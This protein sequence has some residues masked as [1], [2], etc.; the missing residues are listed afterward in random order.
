MNLSLIVFIGFCVAAAV[1]LFYYLVVFT[2][3]Y[4]KPGKSLSDNNEGVSVIICSRNNRAFLE[5]NLPAILGQDH[6]NFEVV[7]VNDGSTDGTIDF[8]DNLA[9]DNNALNVVHLD[10][11]ERFHRGKKFAQT[12]G[13]KA[14]KN[15]QLIFTDADCLP[16]SDQWLKETAR[17][18]TPGKSIILGVGNYVRKASLTNWI[19]QLETFHSLLLYIN[20]AR[21]KMPYMGVG[22][23]LAYRRSLFFEV[24]GFAS[25]QHLL[26]GDDD[27]FVNET[28]TGSNVAISLNPE[29]FTISE[30]KKGLGA[31]MKQKKRHFSTGKLYKPKHRFVLGLYSFSLFLFYALG[32]FLLVTEINQLLLLPE[33]P[34]TFAAWPTLLL[35]TV[36]IILIR[37]IVQG[38]VLHKNMKTFDYSKYFWVYP[39]FDIGILLI[40]I[41]IGIRGY[42]S[43]PQRW[44]S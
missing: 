30:P 32:I 13:I 24:K 43:K 44:N 1:Q 6:P 28:A 26:S 9:R 37:L 33:L 36:G 5:K 20:L 11:D 27:L 8:L 29:A 42:Y 23:N 7:V 12:I 2:K 15:E 35:A 18:F 31:W 25:H 3:I 39:L 4:H 19:I 21:M 10:I 16:A 34:T 17:H 14:A 22:R 38:I 41:F 40:Q